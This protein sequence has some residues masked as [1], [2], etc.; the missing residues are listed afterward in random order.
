MVLIGLISVRKN[1]VQRRVK[2]LLIFIWVSAIEWTRVGNPSFCTGRNNRNIVRFAV[3]NES[4]SSGEFSGGIIDFGGM[5]DRTLPKNEPSSHRTL[6]KI[7]C[8]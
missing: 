7:E 4:A 3:V 5:S 6:Q 1:C 2:P 8:E